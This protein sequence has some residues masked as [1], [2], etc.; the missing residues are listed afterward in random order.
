MTAV[1]TVFTSPRALIRT[2]PPS[3][4]AADALR[5]ATLNEKPLHL[6]PSRNLQNAMTG[7]GCNNY[8]TPERVGAIIAGLMARGGNFIR[9]CSCALMLAYVA[10]GRL[11]GQ[12]EPH[13]RAWDRMG[14]FC[15]VRETGGETLHFRGS[16]AEYL[17]G[18][19]VLAPNASCYDDLLQLHMSNL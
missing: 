18:Y 2:A 11:V 15:L 9:N 17:N 13:M 1:V 19:P 10:A 16:G 14:G 7:I 4:M 8:V 3:G 12:Y 6:E 5:G